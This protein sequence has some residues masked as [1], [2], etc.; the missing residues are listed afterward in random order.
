MRTGIQEGELL[1]RAE[2][3][4]VPGGRIRL[5]PYVAEVHPLEGNRLENPAPVKT[6]AFVISVQ[7][8]MEFQPH[9]AF[10]H[11]VDKIMIFS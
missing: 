2:N 6:G 3:R 8:M 11:V 10:I 1:R 4:I 9:G 5:E 7:G